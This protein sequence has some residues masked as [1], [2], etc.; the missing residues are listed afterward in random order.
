[1]LLGLKFAAYIPK[2]GRHPTLPDWQAA[3]RECRLH[4][5]THTYT[6]GVL[7]DLYSLSSKLSCAYRD[8]DNRSVS[9]INPAYRDRIVVVR[10]Q[11]RHVKNRNFLFVR[12]KRKYNDKKRKTYVRNDMRRHATD[13]V[14]HLTTRRLLMSSDGAVY[15]YKIRTR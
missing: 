11:I 9:R 1:M 3:C 4:T 13:R 7:S 15:T 14:T 12:K 10:S 6:H 2:T 5:N 8:S